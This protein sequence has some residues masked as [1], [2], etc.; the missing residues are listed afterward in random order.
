MEICVEFLMIHHVFNHVAMSF[1]NHMKARM[2][3]ADWTL[4]FDIFQRDRDI[5]NRIPTRR[6]HAKGR[7]TRKAPWPFEAQSQEPV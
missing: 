2:D 3:A 1:L 5:P 7:R 6:L 4:N